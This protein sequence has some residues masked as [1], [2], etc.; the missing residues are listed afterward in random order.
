M[1]ESIYAATKKG[2]FQFTRQAAG[3]AIARTSFLGD[4]ISMVLPDRRDG[5]LYATPYHGHFG[6]KVQRSRDGGV[7][8]EETPAP[9]FPKQPEGETDIDS[10]GKVVAWKVVK[11]WSLVTKSSREILNSVRVSMFIVV[12]QSCP[13]FISPKPL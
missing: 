9:T 3:W 13:A 5:A 1:S 10:M 12:S 11:I 7:T 4:D 2:V 6:A 8:W